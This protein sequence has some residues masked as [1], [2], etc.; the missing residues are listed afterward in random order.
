MIS[1]TIKGTGLKLRH[2]FK[3]PP[4]PSLSRSNA[5][6]LVI[7][8]RDIIGVSLYQFVQ[9][10]PYNLR[11]PLYDRRWLGLCT[12]KNQANIRQLRQAIQYAQM[13]RQSCA[14]A[15]SNAQPRA[16]CRPDSA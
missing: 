12:M 9:T 14:G 4:L 8:A 3:H 6:R 2:L 5:R 10:P 11:Q 1:F 13:L 16:Y 15:D 7:R